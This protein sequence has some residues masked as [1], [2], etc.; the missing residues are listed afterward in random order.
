[1]NL[2]IVGNGPEDERLRADV[3]RRNLTGHVEFISWMPQDKFLRLYDDH[4]VFVFP[5]LHDSTGW[6]VLEALCKGMPVACLDLGG[7]KDIVTPDLGIIIGTGGLDSTQVAASLA[8]ELYALLTDPLR[9]MKLSAGAIA[10][11][12]DFL[13][14]AQVTKLYEDAWRVIRSRKQGMAIQ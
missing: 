11:A 8:E 10:R 7:P 5:S 9:L 12:S 6:V 1:M 13:L 2:T 4:D 3:I 14:S